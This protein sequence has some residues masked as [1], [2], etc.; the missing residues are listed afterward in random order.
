MSKS[1]LIAIAL[2]L[3][4]HIPH[5]CSGQEAPVAA[6]GTSQAR[7]DIDF[8]KASPHRMPASS[9][10]TYELRQKDEI[11]AINATTAA[12]LKSDHFNVGQVGSGKQSP[13]SVPQ[14]T[15]GEWTAPAAHGAASLPFTTVRAD[16]LN[17]ATNTQYPYSATGKLFFL[18][19]DKVA[20]CSASLIKR[21]V[22]LTGAHCI[23][24]RGSKSFFSA[25]KFVPGYRAG[26]APFGVWE[27][28]NAWV[29]Q[30]W[31]DGTDQCVGLA[32]ETD[33][34][35]IVL[36]PKQDANGPF[37]AGRDTGYYGYQVGSTSFAEQG[38]LIT[39][40][41]QLGYPGCLDKGEY[42]ERNDSQAFVS[43]QKSNTM[44]GTLMCQ[45]SSGGPWLI[46]FG[47]ASELSGTNAGF[48]SAPNAVIGVTSWGPTDPSVKVVAASPLLTS[49]I[50]VL[51]NEAC[52]AYPDACRPN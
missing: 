1:G 17:F 10:Y 38:G 49:N 13:G 16:L 2:L 3:V 32:C 40:V 6:S 35:V 46:N 25:W 34:G 22:V 39:H 44:M 30:S 43:S 51:V 7:G 36:G 19:G 29:L 9:Q 42:M 45:G 31:L 26:E 48:A 41:T 24:E 47:Q 21:G 12:S 4:A 5:P 11:L 50:D 27:A 15:R 18:F 33:I 14:P 23:A 37:Y 20:T 28:V 52:N 8:S